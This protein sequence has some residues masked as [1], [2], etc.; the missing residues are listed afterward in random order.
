VKK[1]LEPLIQAFKALGTSSKKDTDLE[2]VIQF[3]KDQARKKLE[4]MSAEDLVKKGSKFGMSS[5][6]TAINTAA[7]RDQYIEH[8][9]RIEAYQKLN[10]LSSN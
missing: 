2:Q 3:E 10:L 4:Q 8:L 5:N 1:K 9:A 7:K 6:P